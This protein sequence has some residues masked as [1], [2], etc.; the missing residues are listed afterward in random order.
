MKSHIRGLIAAGG[1][2]NKN[3]VKATARGIV[4][5]YKPSQ[6]ENIKITDS[7]A[8]SLLIRMKLVKR[9]GWYHG[10]MVDLVLF[11]YQLSFSFIFNYMYSTLIS[12]LSV[13][14]NLTCLGLGVHRC[15]TYKTSQNF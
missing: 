13:S 3:I 6:L 5:H 1:V 15:F 4:K 12:L 8:K 11:I 7:W 14:C 9:K 10:T 2:V